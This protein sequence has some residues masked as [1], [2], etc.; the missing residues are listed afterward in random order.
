[1]EPT[2]LHFPKG[3]YIGTASASYQIEGAVAE[4]GRGPSIWD[5][6]SHTPGKIE[7]GTNGDIA[8]DHYYRYREDVEL[9]QEL[10]VN[11]YRFSISWSRVLPRGRGKVNNKGL[12]FYSALVDELLDAGITPFVT[13]YH[14]DLPQALQDDG[15]WLRRG[16][17]DDF[18]AYVDAVS[19]ELGDRVKHWMTINEPW[20]LAWQ[21]YV[22]G[23][24]APGVKLGNMEA[25]KVSHNVLLAH[26]AAVRTLRENS[27]D[28][29]VGI[30]LHLNMVEPATTRSEDVA[31]AHRWELHQNRW[32][33]DALYREGYPAE[34]VK[35]FGSDAPDVIQGDMELIQAPIDFLGVNNYRRSVVAEG[36]DLP[37]VNMKR[38]S[39]PGEY[40]EMGWEVH[41]EGLYRILKWI[42]TNY[43]VS[44]ILVTENGAS[45]TDTVSP[46]GKVHDERRVAYL[47]EHIKQAHR[48]MR[49]GVPLGGY[50]AWSTL[51]NFEWAYGYSRRFGLIHV[52][53]QTQKRTIKD[54]GYFLSEVA[55][56]VKQ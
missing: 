56:G 32:Y 45:F 7:D 26:G 44:K 22:T 46:D 17:V 19:V 28:A 53:Y 47:R 8:D 51:D 36:T 1:M 18:E 6:Y 21:G 11:A 25:L 49:E 39:P 41:P 40:T 12:Q 55:K 43:P 52:D 33:L 35:L 31:A 10:G 15:G 38:V 37:P 13:L 3:F 23:E 30:V 54:S 4:D 16:I 5:T 20:E 24:D 29:K 14:F 2:Q 48:A 50:F 27:Q 9:M 42:H 34:M